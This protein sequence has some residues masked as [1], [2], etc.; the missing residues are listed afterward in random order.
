[1][2]SPA[3]AR[4]AFYFAQCTEVSSPSRMVRK[5]GAGVGIGARARAYAVV[6]R[7]RGSARMCRYRQ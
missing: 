7:V 4:N 3:M 5:E 6:L 1:M 2:L